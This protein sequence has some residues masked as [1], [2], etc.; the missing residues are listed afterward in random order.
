MK[1]EREREQKYEFCEYG[2]GEL[3]AV[4]QVRP[5][6]AGRCP[7]PLK[8]KPAAN[9]PVFWQ[10]REEV[11]ITIKSRAKA[12]SNSD[13][14]ESLPQRKAMRGTKAVL[15]DA[16]KAYRK[17]PCRRTRTTLRRAVRR[18]AREEERSQHAEHKKRVNVK[19]HQ[20]SRDKMQW[21]A[22]SL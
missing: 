8:C 6:Q 22:G 18:D 14:W 4:A 11:E 3:V 1:R 20:Q 7:T 5:V 9:R 15:K 10:P 2:V 12:D 17:E 21:G 16:K 19:R 13:D